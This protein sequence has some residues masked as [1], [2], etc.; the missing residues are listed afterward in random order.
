MINISVKEFSKG[1][2]DYLESISITEQEVLEILYKNIPADII[3]RFAEIE[4]EN[5]ALREQVA[6]NTKTLN[7]IS[8][9]LGLYMKNEVDDTGLW[10]EDLTD[11]DNITHIESLLLDVENQRLFGAPGNVI[12]KDLIIPFVSDQITASITMDYNFIEN[13]ADFNAPAG[14]STFSIDR[15]SYEVK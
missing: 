7:T 3:N 4:A 6:A 9:Y 8:I 13:I 5:R 10:V 2:K 12:F 1:L 15:Y 11:G 14:S